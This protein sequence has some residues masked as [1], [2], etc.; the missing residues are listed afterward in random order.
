MLIKDATVKSLVRYYF[1][2]INR[3]LWSS[4][5]KDEEA[6]F[7]TA[8][9]DRAALEVRVAGPGTAETRAVTVRS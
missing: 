6:S 2:G 9:N 3:L 7:D 4:I 5:A 1:P 8:D